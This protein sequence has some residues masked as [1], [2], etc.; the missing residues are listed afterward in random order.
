MLRDDTTQ[1]VEKIS[2]SVKPDVKGK[3]RA[4]SEEGVW[5]YIRQAQ[6]PA[7]LRLPDNIDFGKLRDE[8][9][10]GTRF[11]EQ[12]LQKFGAEVMQTVNKHVGLYDDDDDEEPEGR[13]STSS[14]PGNKRIL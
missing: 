4:T 14:N 13:A 2:K 5:R 1:T 9:D 7:A 12:Y 3:K 6:L 8:M 11:A 10:Q